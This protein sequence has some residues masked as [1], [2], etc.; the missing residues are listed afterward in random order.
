M[1]VLGIDAGGTKTVCLLAD[2]QGAIVSEGRG[3]GA[4]LH[5]AGELAVEKVLHEVMEEAIGDRAITPAAI[6]L[7]IAGVDRDDEAR[8]VRAIMRRIGY[9]SRVLVVNDALI[10][11][12]AGARDEPGIAIIAG[13][14]S[15]VYGRNAAFE[16]ARA[17]GWGHM[18]GDEGS[19]YW[20]GRESLAAVM[21]AADG[22]GPETRLTA[23][24]LSHFNVDDESRLPRNRLRPRAA[25]GQ[26]RGARADRP[27]GG[28][29]GRCGGDADSRARR[30]RARARGAFGG[31]PPRDARRRVHVL[32]GRRRL[33]RRAVA[34]GGAASAGCSRSRRARRRRSLREEPAVG[35]VWLALAEARGGARVPV[36]AA[37][38][39]DQQSMMR[40]RVFRDRRRA[41]AR[42]GAPT[43]RARLA[44][45]PATRAR[46]AD[47][48]HADPA[49]SRAGPPAPAPAAPT[50]AARR[51]SISTSSSAST[52]RDP[53]SYRA[54][55]QRHLFDHV[56]LAP[57]RIHFLNGATRD[58]DAEC[59]RYERAIARAGGIDLQILG[60]G[61]NGH[62]GFNE[63]ARALVA[64]THCTRLTPATRRAN[65]AFFGGRVERGAARGAV[66]GDGDDSPRA[67]DRAARDRGE[68]RRAASSG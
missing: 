61:T 2:E 5:T 32:S 67:A 49:V 15:I 40:L 8:T 57:R 11:L 55:M 42:A 22:R 31:D 14:G 34:G 30:R 39:A 24:I 21:R 51:R 37:A 16:A 9:K 47:R 12:V 23:E 54:F 28:R 27:A 43:S 20:I 50:S 68:R 26:R 7:G 58:V 46:A 33:S 4:N 59:R 13:T 48:P 41:G 25:A 53:H 52:R 29:A 10:A 60:L 56:N 65:A 6:C 17:G 36:Q 66:D 44:A 38:M 3:A 19:G 63:P 64:R 62:I 45:T 18:I 1:H 35:A